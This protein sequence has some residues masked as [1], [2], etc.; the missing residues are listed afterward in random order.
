MKDLIASELHRVAGRRLVR[1]TLLLIA[2]LAVA[3]G[4]LTFAKT[5]KIS[6]AEHR[7]RERQAETEQ[8]AQQAQTERCLR[9]HGVEAKE[10][11]P[12]SVAEECF[13]DRFPSAHD[14]RFHRSRLKGLLEGVSGVLA[15]VAW[16]IGASLVGAE[17]SSRGVTTLLTWEP[18][19]SRVFL[20]KAVAA[21]T[22]TALVA[23]V[24]LAGVV[25]VMLPSLTAHGAPLG[26]D[27][28]TWAGLAGLVARGTALAALAGGIGFGLA[29]IARNTAA[30]LGVGFAYV[31]V[32]ENI[33]GS[34]L[35]D[36]R[37][38][39]LLGNLIVF[40]VGSADASDVPG[41]SVT[42]AGTFLLVVA[43]GVLS[44]AATTFRAR[45]IG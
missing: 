17:F 12:Q 37:R 35:E 1:L 9:S 2:L 45:D 32:L 10:D 33:L 11:V 31:I 16:A 21:I 39:L 42:G 18:R 7:Q 19:R 14:P 41:R 15:V 28:P 5:S 6:E 38:W 30:A 40:L 26:P 36:W 23:V 27:E 25:L 34:S 43:V 22:A 4:V 13:P 3:G 20:A 29:T 44:L 24:T 8:E